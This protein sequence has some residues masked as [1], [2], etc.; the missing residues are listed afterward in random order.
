MAGFDWN[1]NGKTDN[2]DR[3]MDMEMMSNSSNSDSDDLITEIETQT[4]APKTT[5]HVPQTTKANQDNNV[6][7]IGKSFLCVSVCILGF[8]IC[9]SANI[10]KLGMS[11][12]MI[13]AATLGYFIMKK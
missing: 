11:L 1:A 4:L 8:A 10:G 6:A 12:V 7:V 5:Q 13:G 3:F 2:F 9:L